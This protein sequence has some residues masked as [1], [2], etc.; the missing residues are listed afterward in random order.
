VTIILFAGGFFY[1]FN[2][3]PMQK[4]IEKYEEKLDDLETEVN[5]KVEAFEQQFQKISETQSEEFKALLEETQVE[6]LNSEEDIRKKYNELERKVE[7]LITSGQA[8]L[9]EIKGKIKDSEL[10]QMWSDHYMWGAR[11][12][13]AN[14][15]F[16]LILLI[17]K[18]LEYK[19]QEWKIRMALDNLLSALDD[20]EK[21]KL[22]DQEMYNH[23]IITLDQI[24]DPE[25]E[26]LTK[27]VRDRFE[28]I[29]E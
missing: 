29:K 18:I 17:D 11:K 22:K 2:L 4:K 12:I 8:D 27:K 9:D 3:N 26:D 7:N 24:K 14:V 15:I 20:A 21:E 5:E 6:I 13:T 19:R 10:N 16:V 28:V 25:V 23:A 1:L